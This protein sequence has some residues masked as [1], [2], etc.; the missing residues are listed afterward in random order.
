[1]QKLTRE[2][3]AADAAAASTTAAA[4]TAGSGTKN[5]KYTAHKAPP[6]GGSHH[7]ASVRQ[8][9]FWEHFSIV[10]KNVSEGVSIRRCDI[11]NFAERREL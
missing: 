3:A 8:D 2:D 7:Y 5:G 11:Y 6:D 10:R 9:E 4:A 1:M